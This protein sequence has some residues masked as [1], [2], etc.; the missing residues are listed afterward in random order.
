LKHAVGL[1]GGGALGELVGGNLVIRDL[2]AQECGYQ[3]RG[4]ASSSAS[5]L[6]ARGCG[7][8]EK[9]VSIKG[10]IIRCSSV[11]PDLKEVVFHCLVCGFYSESVMVDTGIILV[12]IVV[13][14]SADLWFSFL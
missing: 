8:L 6:A 9:M 7:L 12:W 5:D 11:I 4:T 14:P 10:M 2:A 3:A 1:G 13:S